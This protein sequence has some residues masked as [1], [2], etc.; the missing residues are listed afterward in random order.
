MY[1]TV[2]LPSKLFLAICGEDVLWFEEHP[3]TPNTK[4]GNKIFFIS[5]SGFYKNKT[6]TTTG[7]VLVNFDYLPI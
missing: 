7:V 5:N 1:E 3:T 6:K 2:E 4:I